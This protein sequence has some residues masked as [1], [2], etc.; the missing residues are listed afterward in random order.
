MHQILIQQILNLSLAI[1]QGVDSQFSFYRITLSVKTLIIH[2]QP[3]LYASDKIDR[4]YQATRTS[5]FILSDIKRSLT[6]PCVLY[7][8]L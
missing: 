2:A 8:Y 3:M 1:K 4:S 5:S 7:L 6:G